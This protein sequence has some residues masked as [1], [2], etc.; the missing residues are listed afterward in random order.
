MTSA[1]LE[2]RAIFPGPLPVEILPYTPLTASDPELD[3]D[4]IPYIIMR[5]ADFLS[6]TANL[7]KQIKA[8]EEKFDAVVIPLRGGLFPGSAVS[9]ALNLTGSTYYIGAN[10]YQ[11]VQAGSEAGEQRLNV[12]LPLDSGVDFSGQKVLLADEVN[13]TSTTMIELKRILMN[14]HHADLVKT[15]VLHEKPG[16]RKEEADFAVDRSSDAWIVYLWEHQGSVDFEGKIL[17]QP[18][19]FFVDQLPVWMIRKD[20]DGQPVLESFARAMDRAR[21]I[22]FEDTE[23]P[24]LSDS[25]FLGRLATSLNNRYKDNSMF[26]KSIPKE[27]LGLLLPGVDLA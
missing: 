6:M 10:H 8:S 7:I 9:S 22:G 2:R 12:Y 23:L 19:E 25:D 16:R 24:S 27:S 15:A 13:H 1:V 11:G 20:G 26:G 14:I 4:G 21:A 3:P 5:E 17:H 18:Y